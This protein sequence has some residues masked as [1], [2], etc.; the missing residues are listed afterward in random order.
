[1]DHCPSV[2]SSRPVFDGDAEAPESRRVLFIGTDNFRAGM[3]SARRMAETL[4][5]Q[6]RIVVITIPAQLSLDERLR[7]VN[8]VLKK[9][10]GIKIVRTFDDKGDPRNAYDQISGILQSKEKIDGIIGLEAS[11]DTLL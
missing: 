11:G 6:G 3:E 10:P 1:M 8:E 7:G 9:Y 4:H 2:L 5:S